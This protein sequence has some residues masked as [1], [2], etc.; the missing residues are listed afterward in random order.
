MASTQPAAT[1]EH[2]RLRALV[3]A[4]IALSSELSLD[5]LLQRLVETAAALTRARYAALGVINASGR[6]LERFITTGMDPATYAAI[7]ELPRGRGIL[8]VLIREAETLRLHDIG[9]DPRSVGFPPNH[10]PMRTFLGVP[11]LLRG[12]AYGNL[13][14]TEK[15]SGDFNEDD[16]EL[17]G[18]LATQAAVAIENARLYESST[19]WSRQ[20]ESLNEIFAAIA[21]ELELPRLLGL[22]ARR[23]REMLDARLVTIA[24]PAAEGELRVEAADGEAA[25][26]VLGTTLPRDASKHGRVLGRG[27]SERV[28]S[29]FDDPEIDQATARQVR[30]RAGLFVPLLAGGRAIG[31]IAA[32]DRRGFDVRFTEADLRIAELFA[33]RA[34]VAVDL[35]QRVARDTFARTVE[36]QEAER[37]R[38]AR[39]LHDQVGQ[40]LTSVLLGLKA[41]EDAADDAARAAAIGDVREQVVET[42]HDV[43]RLAVEL[44]PKALDD[45][46]LVPALERL[47]TTIAERS[48]IRIDFAPQVQE[49]LRQDVETALYRVVQEALTN[50]VKHSGAGA[51][52]VVLAQGDDNVTAVVEDDGRG[53]EPHDNAEGFGLAAMAERLALIGGRLKIESG[54][55]KGTTIVAEAPLA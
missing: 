2:E 15:E 9:D 11:V 3:A 50:V 53:F 48:G 45:F 6:E 40:D 37:R 30:A 49:R 34:A 54:A 13:Y 5:A 4:G 22:I 27:R 28:D 14:L 47:T 12:V 7:G 19:A 51:A 44:R 31:V 10:P 33:V 52:S 20:L 26:E 1:D 39:E 42:L 35:S 25:D 8:G 32:H 43:R 55:G 36:A 23:L 16:E 24:L 29:V 18:L 17:V 41:V 46:G 38:L 21:S